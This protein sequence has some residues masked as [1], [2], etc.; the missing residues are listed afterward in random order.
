MSNYVPELPL[1]MKPDSPEFKRRDLT[2]K[3]IDKAQMLNRDMGVVRGH[4][5]ARFY[6]DD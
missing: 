4:E 2:D 3:N 5:G 6:D 1:Q